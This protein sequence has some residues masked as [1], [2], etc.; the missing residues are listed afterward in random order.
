MSHETESEKQKIGEYLA[1]VLGLKK[2]KNDR[3]N[4]SWGDKTPIG[5]YL[6]V[7]RIIE[8]EPGDIAALTHMDNE[9]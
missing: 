6:T 4:T 1:S 7:K 2:K 3:D 5:L 9:A 8:S